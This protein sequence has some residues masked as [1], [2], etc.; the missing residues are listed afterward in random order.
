MD[1]I[2]RM[3]MSNQIFLFWE[4]LQ[5]D[6]LIFMEGEHRLWLTLSSR[7]SKAHM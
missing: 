2:K 1:Y 5:K 7:M 4:G 6:L 3:K